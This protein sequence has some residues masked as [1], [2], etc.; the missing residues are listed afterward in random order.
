MLS[1]VYSCY[2]GVCCYGDS[3]VNKSLREQLEGIYGKQELAVKPKKRRKENLSHTD[4]EYIM[5]MYK[6]TY[7][8]AKGGALRQR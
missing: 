7:T 2:R 4:W 3:I 8:R 1:V 5:G 6:P